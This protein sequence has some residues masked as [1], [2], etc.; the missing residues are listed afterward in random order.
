[1]LCRWFCSKLKGKKGTYHVRLRL[2]VVPL[3]G[4]IGAIGVT[5]QVGWDSAL[6]GHLDGVL[7]S[8][9]RGSG[10]WLLCAAAFVSL[11]VVFTKNGKL[12]PESFGRYQWYFFCGVCCRAVRRTSDVKRLAGECANVGFV[13]ERGEDVM[14]E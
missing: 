11:R 3:G 8:C 1:M 12:S 6:R 5:L 14:G 13:G 9:G 7:F 4:A 10:G 2:A